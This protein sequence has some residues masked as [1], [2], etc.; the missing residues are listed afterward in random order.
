VQI[1]QIAE[2]LG[3]KDTFGSN[4]AGSDELR[5]S[6]LTGIPYRGYEAL[7]GGFGLEAT[8]VL[9]VLN[10]PLRTLAR[11]KHSKRFD[12]EESDRLSR[13]ARVAALAEE[14]LGDRAKAGRWLQKPNRALGGADP[15]DRIAT[16]VGT[17]EV[18]EVLGRI[19][20]GVFS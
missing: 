12:P 20:H 18:E 3:G 8:P 14:V 4:I 2:A 11:R 6:I 16:D 17:R 10:V 1:S 5:A 19:A 13:L 9:A 15:L 7:I